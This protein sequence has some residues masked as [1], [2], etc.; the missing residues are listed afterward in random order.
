ML[1]SRKTEVMK[2]T[3]HMGRPEQPLTFIS[4]ISHHGVGPD[5][6]VKFGRPSPV[7]VVFHLSSFQYFFATYQVRFIHVYLP[8]N[9][10]KLYIIL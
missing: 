10:G 6:L 2:E 4:P 3:L 5:T 9:R 1:I 8:K 7:E